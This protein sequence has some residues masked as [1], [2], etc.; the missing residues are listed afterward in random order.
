MCYHLLLSARPGIVVGLQRGYL[1]RLPVF[2]DA[3][4]D[5]WNI[6]MTCYCLRRELL[7]YYILS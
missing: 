5:E 7:L 3:S 6:G 2:S 1:P 4:A